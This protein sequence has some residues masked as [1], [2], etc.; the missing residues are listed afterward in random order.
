MDDSLLLTVPEAARKLRVC[1]QTVY[2]LMARGELRSV[3]IGRARRIPVAELKGWVERALA[4]EYG[5]E[6]LA[7]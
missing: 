2:E 5:D 7:G 1:R 4:Q 3:R 6:D